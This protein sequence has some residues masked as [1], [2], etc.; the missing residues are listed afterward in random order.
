[1]GLA[2]SLAAGAKCYAALA[3]WSSRPHG[4]APARVP[5]GPAFPVTKSDWESFGRRDAVERVL[6]RAGL[7][8]RKFQGLPST[9]GQRADGPGR[10]SDPS[11]AC[12]TFK[13]WS[14]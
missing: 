11:G 7:G 10:S 4:G 3:S 14:L 6:D 2:V 12:H 9:A 1:M 5:T 13:C 8:N